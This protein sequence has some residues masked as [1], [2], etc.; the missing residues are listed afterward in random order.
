M[1][2]SPILFGQAT[3]TAAKIPSAI[4]DGGGTGT[5]GY[6]YAVYVQI[7]GWTSGGSGQAYV[8]IYSGSN[9]EFMWSAT[10]AWS[11]S[12]TYSS[13][14]QP[15]VDIDASGNWSGW[16]YL[17]H[18]SALVQP[19]RLR[20][21]KV[22]ATSTNITANLSSFALLTT[23]ASG[24][25]G[26]IVRSSSPAVNKGILAYAG[27]TI[28]GSYRSEDN[29]ITEG[30]AY[31]AG[32]FKIAVPIGFVDS[33]VTVNDDGSRDQAFVGPW[34]ITAGQ[35]TDASIGGG[36]VGRGTAVISPGILAG[37]LSHPVTIKIFGEAPYT[38]TDAK[39]TVPLLWTWS[40]ATSDISLIGGGGPV[41]TVVGNTIGISGMTL[42]GGDSLQVTVSGLVPPDS[43]SYFVF[44]TKTGTAPDSINPIGSQPSTFVYSTPRPISS[45]KEN[46]AAGVPV[47]N[48]GLVTVRGIVTVANQFGGP[49]YIQDNSGGLA[50][51]GSTFSVAVNIG[52]EVVVSGLVQP[53]NGLTE[54][55]NPMLQ[56][57][58]STGNSVQ[59]LLVTAS[60]IAN[61]GAGGVELYEG[62]LVRLNAVTIAG[63]GAWAYQNYPLTDAS[64]T[65]ELRIDNN[66][67]LI[68]VAIPGSSFDVIGVVG[69]FIAT[70]PYIGGYQV[71]PRFTAD[72]LSAGPVFVTFPVETNIQ[73][74]RLTIGWTTIANGTTHAFYGKTTAFELGLAGSDSM[75]TDH[76]LVLS[77]LDPATVY[78]IKAFSASGADTSF[79]STLIASTAS[80]PPATGVI[81]AYFNHSV[82]TDLAWPTAA[83][84]SQDMVARIVTRINNAHRSIDAALYSLSGT[85]GAN[86]AAALTAAKNRGVNVRIICE[87]DNRNTAPFTNLSGIVPLID[88]AF[89]AVNQGVGLMHNKFVV[90]DGRGGAPDSVWVWTGSCNMTDPGTLDD[91]Q[92]AVEVQDPAL[93]G[94]Y[95]LEFNE[96]WGSATDAPKASATRFGARKTDNTPHR[97]VIGG[98][99]VES[100]FSPSD[101]T[102]SRIL[103][104]VN[105][106]QHSLGFAVLSF[107]RTDI[108]G[109]ILAR[110]LAGVKV[111]GVFDKGIDQF[112]QYTY[113]LGNGADVHLSTDV[114]P[115]D[116]LFHHKYAVVDAEDP[117]WNPVV[118]TGSHN[119]SS[120]A[121][122]QNDENSLIIRD[123]A[124][125]NQYLQE[126][127][128]RYYQ[129]GGG[130]SITVG[131]D[132]SD[133]GV[134]TSN[135]LLQNYPNPFNPST[136]ISYHLTALSH[137]NLK[138]FD[139]LGREVTTLVDARQGPGMY[140]VHVNGSRLAS[141]VYFY[142]I[143]AGNFS[144]VRKMILLR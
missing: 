12:T 66:T 129:F 88:D 86:V 8:K 98:R 19:A 117:S 22:G 30:Y 77:F 103:G 119:W 134:P 85:A 79:A 94:A 3:I 74:S 27:G 56:S 135:A 41:D 31:P 122:N 104:L 109:A 91:Y 142:R 75:R 97:F 55:V 83:A 20:A 23:S 51:F 115:G 21:A 133:R 54:I 130:D 137:V 108:A 68:G 93:A 65:T 99:N 4:A 107:T 78:Y 25:G 15:L 44:F 11:N 141:G 49:S 38:I 89:D 114:G 124:I 13:A 120:S 36:Q 64:G 17:K 1:L 46:D 34:A 96:M 62:Q 132:Q 73:P 106:A 102:T 71:M 47:R 57:I 7:Q 2:F 33:L 48:N 126:F 144:A 18:N 112:S 40:H 70:S 121:E 111:R 90:I 110:K 26:W 37:T 131:V 81:N 10:G 69:Q 116:G 139:I 52:D 80:A 92:N 6:P 87:H 128:A 127:A 143:S 82:R 28:V 105:G 39:I 113:L 67:D 123:A 53:F 76:T 29:G 59:P 58:P 125:A 100:Y 5:T 43:T 95:E 84:G 138:L 61:D 45:V 118:L 72:I 14:N 24:N 60:Q 50:I 32:G 136:T 42:N 16:I 63:G 140:A 101:R 9:N 35:E